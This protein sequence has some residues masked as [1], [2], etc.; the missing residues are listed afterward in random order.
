MHK[1]KNS[2]ESYFWAICLFLYESSIS[3]KKPISQKDKKLLDILE[4]VFL[5]I[6]YLFMKYINYSISQ[7]A[8]EP[9]SI[10]N[11]VMMIR[12]TELYLEP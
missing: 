8:L 6:V 3:R 2:D 10:Q 9:S 11:D 7:I 1:V 5:S 12:N 4:N